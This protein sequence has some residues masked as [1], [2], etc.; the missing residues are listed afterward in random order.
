MPLLKLLLQCFYPVFLTVAVSLV[1]DAEAASAAEPVRVIRSSR[2]V[3][4]VNGLVRARFS[5]GEGV[6]HDS[7]SIGGDIFSG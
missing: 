2:D 1:A 5:V 6:R 7:C 3:S 4:I